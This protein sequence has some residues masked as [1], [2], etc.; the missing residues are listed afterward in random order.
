MKLLVDAQLPRR[1]AQQLAAL[2]HDVIHTLDLPLANQTSDLSIIELADGA[3]RVVITKD[4]DFVDSFV[5]RGEPARLLLVSTGNIS[6]RDLEALF[7]RHM[8]KSRRRLRRADSLNLAAF[9]S[10][11]TRDPSPA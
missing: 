10:Q 9:N 6:N 1:L 11:F 4:R 8:H 2:G 7:G 5:L 3:G